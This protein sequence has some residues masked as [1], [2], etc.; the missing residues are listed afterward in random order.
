LLFLLATPLSAQLRIGDSAAVVS[1]VRRF[2]AALDAGDT[3]ALRGLL[4]P[5]ARVVTRGEVRQLG[6]EALDSEIRWERAINR[7]S[8]Q[9]SVRVLGWAAY[10][11]ASA[12][13]SAKANPALISGVEV[14]SYVLSRL[15]EAW[16]IELIH[17]SVGQPD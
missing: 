15:G 2:H 8:T 16:F 4:A 3:V 6:G 5:G 13:V 7:D 14:R 11:L 17:G 12:K 1:T 10:V 9:L